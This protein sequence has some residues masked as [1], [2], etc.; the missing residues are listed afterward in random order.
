M[1]IEKRVKA[2]NDEF[3][4]K[5]C[6]FKQLYAS[7]M[8]LIPDDWLRWIAATL[9]EGANPDFVIGELI[10]QGL[11]SETAE[12]MVSLTLKRGRLI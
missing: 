2:F 8:Q 1:I 12:K 6:T 11:D 4:A 9:E 7:M 10:N 5:G 3:G